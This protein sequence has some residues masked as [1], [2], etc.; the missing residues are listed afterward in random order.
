MLLAT[1]IVSVAFVASLFVG[2]RTYVRQRQMQ[3]WLGATISVT[4]GL[5]LLALRGIAPPLVSVL[6]GNVTIM[7]G[8][9]AMLIGYQLAVDETPR[10]R[11]SQLSIGISV[12]LYAT[13]YLA[14]DSFIL[15][16]IVFSGVICATSVFGARSLLRSPAEAR[17][18]A[19]VLSAALL[20]LVAILQFL[21]SWVTLRDGP[22]T[23]LSTGTDALAIILATALLLR[24][25]LSLLWLVMTSERQERDASLAREE[26]DRAT[27]A[28]MRAVR[29]SEERFALAVEGASTGVWHWD[30]ASNTFFISP[31]GKSVLGYADHEV[32]S[33]YM[34][35]TSRLHPNEST[36]VFASI[37]RFLKGRETSL[38]LEHRLRHKDG[39]YRWVQSRGA[40]LREA[41]GRVSRIAGSIED[42]T[43]RRQLEHAQTFVAQYGH[44]GAGEE[45]FQSL[46]RYLAETLE[47]HTVFIDRLTAD[48]HGTF[49][50]AAFVEG[51]SVAPVEEQ[52][53]DTELEAFAQHD[54]RYFATDAR[55]AF[56]ADE[57]LRALAA[58]S[59]AGIVLRSGVGQAIGVISVIGLA[60]LKDPRL[61][62]SLLRLFAIPAAGEMLRKQTN[63]ALRVREEYSRTLLS[64]LPAGVIVHAP[65]TR[66]IES[67]AMASE[68]TG[69]TAEQLN[70]KVAID[71]AWAFLREDLTPMP[72]D[73][74]PVFRVTSTGLPIN[75]LVVGMCVP[76]RPRV[77]WALCN[78]YPVKDESGALTQIVVTFVDCSERIYAEEARAQLESQLRQSQKMEAVG[79]LAAGIAHDFNNLLTVITG[80]ADLAARGPGGDSGLQRDLADIQRAGQRAA[81]L[82]R[83]LLAFGRKQAMAPQVL[84]L[85]SLIE[86]ITPLLKRVIREDI[87]LEFAP[88]AMVGEVMADPGQMEQ[89]L[90]NLAL[91]ARDA[92]PNGGLLSFSLDEVVVDGAFG[93]AHPSVPLGS[94]VRINVRDTGVGM[95]EATLARVFEPYFTTKEPGQGTGLG[96]ATAY[97]IVSQNRGAIEV[98][99]S[100]GVGSTF[101]VYLPLVTARAGRVASATPSMSS[102]R[103]PDD[104]DRR[105][106]VPPERALVSGTGSILVVEDEGAIRRL[107][108]RILQSAGYVVLTADDGADALRVLEA[109]AEAVDLLLT[110]VVMPH[111]SGPELAARVHVLYPSTKVLFTSGYAGG[112][113]VQLDLDS[114]STEFLSKPYQVAELT[115]KVDE[116]MRKESPR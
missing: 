93:H 83:Q 74:Y 45:F 15:R 11:S 31:N 24:L 12:A 52:A 1:L 103:I 51:A 21:R 67:N 115:R 88:G 54:F 33:G 78:A 96:L 5:S 62:E 104:M 70:G 63:E 49:S 99:S 85:R 30:V 61:A 18:S 86:G 40:A 76:G 2:W 19:R 100:P 7:L 97:G 114:V 25:L 50:E 91:N 4:L 29:K 106:F 92:M 87:R 98:T 79:Q 101:S 108:Q 14:F 73:Q 95:D 55:S 116:I 17:S 107:A 109:R 38:F 90:L 43:L 56:R 46:A 53:R 59:Y 10:W 58:V 35:W 77:T 81:T 69:L 112:A 42:V 8:M 36:E 6:F 41:S 28:G 105:A 48:G 47:A 16:G 68:I 9:W 102:A 110:D 66:I 94:Y 26:H 57:R 113:G 13:F 37:H 80:I 75:G 72:L 84:T 39:A 32:P 22:V 64:R 20:L 65:D 71:P 3:W 111:M 89:V 27:E 60:P 44:V 82:T 34:E 23:N